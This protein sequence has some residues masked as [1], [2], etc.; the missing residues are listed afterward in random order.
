MKIEIINIKEK[1]L[2]IYVTTNGHVTPMSLLRMNM[3][4]DDL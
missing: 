2:L 4:M 3:K 1:F